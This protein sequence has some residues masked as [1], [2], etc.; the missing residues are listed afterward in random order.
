MG[1][2]KVIYY[3]G[4][5]SYTDSELAGFTDGII[6]KM[7][8]NPA[9]IDLA[10]LLV[11]LKATNIDFSTLIARASSGDREIIAQK[12][13]V[14]AEVESQLAAIAFK[15][16]TISQGDELVILSS[17]YKVKR[18]SE[19]V[20]MLDKPE[21][22]KAVPGKRDGTIDV[23]CNVVKNARMYIIQYTLSPVT[24]D[25]VWLWF[26]STKRK[27]TIEKLLAFQNYCLKMAGV[28]TDPHLIWSEIV[29]GFA[30]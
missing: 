3:F 21:N 24:P 22:V 19:H 8:K 16:Q 23:S 1:K 4:N 10:P 9:F 14:R 26:L 17:G 5:R 27:A 30:T 6:E 20:G 29:T 28:G 7:G 18:K 13:A 12:N 15:V 2:S 11:S 25:S